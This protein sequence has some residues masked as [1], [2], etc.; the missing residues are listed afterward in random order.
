M[1][2]KSETKQLLNKIKA[3]YPNFYLEDY[4]VDAWVETLEPYEYEDSLEHFKE[5]LKNN[6]NKTPQPHV[7]IK[8]MLTPEEKK[9]A[10]KDYII[11]CNLCGKTMLY[12]NF[13]EHHKKCLLCKA[14]ETKAKEMKKDLTYEDFMRIDY[15]KLNKGYGHLFEHKL[16]NKEILERMS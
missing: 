5:Y 13:E 14:L 6:P 4:I 10:E 8:G 3:Y 16:T 15:E 9:L 12:S 11:D 7:F 1:M 2:K